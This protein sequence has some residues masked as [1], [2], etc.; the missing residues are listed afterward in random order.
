M[1][2]NRDTNKAI[3]KEQFFRLEQIV[4]A[5]KAAENT[6]A[7]Q[8][9]EVN[10]LSKDYSPEFLAGKQQKIQNDFLA[11]K[12]KLYDDS[13]KQLEKLKTTLL[14]FHGSLDL[15]DPALTNAVTLIKSIGKGLDYENV[16]KINAQFSGNQ[17]ALRILQVAYKAA[18]VV[19]DGGLDKQIYDPSSA[20]TEL[21][22]FAEAALVQDGYSP[23]RL[24]VE[25]GKIAA[26][27]NVPFPEGNP[28]PSMVDNTSKMDAKRIMTAAR[29]A[30]GLGDSEPK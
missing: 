4:K 23:F 8:L 17:P 15:A 1:T 11:T 9:A 19:S 2:N 3:I 5:A 29:D 30:A 13:K 16:A 27:E 22:K 7:A 28:F 18:G 20:I 6:R 25:I 12:Q 14:E 24:G 10:G 26:L 21:G